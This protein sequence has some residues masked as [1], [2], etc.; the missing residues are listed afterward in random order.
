MRAREFIDNTR[1]YLVDDSGLRFPDAR[2]LI[3]LNDAL[4]DICGM[5]RCIKEEFSISV[6]EGMNRYGL[7]D[8]FSSIR[9]LMFDYPWSWDEVERGRL[10]EIELLESSWFKPS[11]PEIYDIWG[12]AHIEKITEL[13]VL[14]VNTINNLTF[15]VEGQIAG[16]KPGDIV[17]NLSDSQAQGE[18]VAFN[19]ETLNNEPRT[20]IEYTFLRGGA[21]RIFNVDDDVR[22]V[23][24][25]IFQQ[26]LAISPSPI[27]SDTGGKASLRGFGARFH[28]PV[29][30]ETMDNGNDRLEIDTEMLTALR[31]KTMEYAN[32]AEY[33]VDHRATQS[34]KREFLMA[35]NDAL[36]LVNDRFEL[37]MNTWK[38]RI[39]RRRPYVTVTGPP[40]P[41]YNP[42]NTGNIGE[43]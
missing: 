31:Y 35:F 37:A 13:P 38:K 25:D 9:L 39:G 10:D 23:S 15:V 14:E 43:R 40:D 3:F 42:Y 33:G 24:P 30:Q 16:L 11:Y 1:M 22:V 34:F 6:V 41:L 18:L 2:M 32:L 21:R 12:K 8:E 27:E 4:R 36:P 20:R 7:M 28:L 17:I 19:H 26:V 5:A 29:T